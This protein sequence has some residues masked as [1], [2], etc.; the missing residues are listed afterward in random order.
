[1]RNPKLLLSFVLLFILS[2]S[3]AQKNEN[4]GST[5]VF[6]A[7]ILN[8]G[9]GYEHSIGKT[10]T[11][12]VQAF[13]NFSAVF[14]EDIYGERVKTDIYFDPAF[15]AQYR[16]YYNFNKR[17]NDGK[18]TDMNSAN[19]V[20]AVYEGIFSKAPLKN[21]LLEE[22]ERRLFSR[23]GAVWGLQRN[24]MKRF[25]LDLNV[26]LGYLT[27]K[28]TKYDG[29]NNTKRTTTEGFVTIMGQ[30]NIGFWLNNPRK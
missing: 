30:I 7:T 20:A 17:A 23:I 28:S 21:D 10:Q 22:T 1:M 3:K 15:T 6:K 13:M 14:Y 5:N 16:Y 19:Y 24:Y 26:G 25:S 27:G 9:I 18:R 2:I 11:I 29:F 4:L 12:A 8:P